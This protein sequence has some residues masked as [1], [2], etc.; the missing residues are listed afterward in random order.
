MADVTGTPVPTGA[1]PFR[2]SEDL[3]ALAD[4]FGAPE[5]FQVA[6]AA[7]L[8]ASGNWVGRRLPVA[9]TGVTYRWDGSS[10]RAV[11]SGVRFKA[12][13]VSTETPIGGVSIV[14]FPT[15]SE[16]T[17]SGWSAGT[18]TV[19][20]GGVYLVTAQLRHTGGVA[21]YFNLMKNG[22]QVAFSP[23]SATA[24]GNGSTLTDYV[25]CNAGDTLQILNGSAFTTRSDLGDSSFF[26]IVRLS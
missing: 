13:F 9:D 8:P 1:S 22:V 25:V 2:V 24:A 6:N 10:W 23:F 21:V 15:V 14:N 19:K 4:H 16:D 17:V 12:A 3:E 7:A 18:Y 26:A 11:T 20:V 5:M